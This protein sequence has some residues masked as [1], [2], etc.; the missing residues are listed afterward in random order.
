MQ[1]TCS[2][3]L[4]WKVSKVLPS[5]GHFWA[6]DCCSAL[7]SPLNVYWGDEIREQHKVI[8]ILAEKQ[9]ETPSSGASGVLPCSVWH[10][11]PDASLSLLQKPYNSCLAAP[12][13]FYIENHI[14][15]NVEQRKPLCVR[16]PSRMQAPGRQGF[17][18]FMMMMYSPCLE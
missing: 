16:G 14:F 11:K 12:L 2:Y 5:T 10:R 13:P 4:L 7:A 18:F 8:T 9:H 3:L 15:T 6:I 1:P 17:C